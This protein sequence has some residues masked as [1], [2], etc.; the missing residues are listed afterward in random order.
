MSA[1][2]RVGLI[3]AEARGGV[4]GADGTMPWHVPEDLQHFRA[5]TSGQPVVMGR[6]TWESLPA[7]FRPLPGRVNVVVSR[8]LGWVAP[9]AMVFHSLRDAVVAA[10]AHVSSQPAPGAFPGMVWV[11][12]GATLYRQALPFAD[13]LVVTELDVDVVGDAHAPRID[14]GWV[15]DGDVAAWRVSVSGVPFRVV[16]YVRDGEFQRVGVRDGEFGDGE[17]RDVEFGDGEFRDVEFGDGEFRDGN[18]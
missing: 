3:W 15:R 6:R 13:C 7:S 10:S 14:A 16:R 18:L 11:I 5:V 17:F 8:Q 9:G 4:I 12:G 2:F 1:P